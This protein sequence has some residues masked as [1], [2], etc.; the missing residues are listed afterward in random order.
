LPAA[1]R[2]MQAPVMRQVKAGQQTESMDAMVVFELERYVPPDSE[3]GFFRLRMIPRQHESIGTLPKQVVFVIDSSSSILQRKLDL[4]RRG[5][6]DTVRRLRP[7]DRFNIVLF[8]DNPK[9]FRPEPVSPSPQTFEALET[10]LDDLESR[11]QTDVYNSI[12]PVLQSRSAVGG[13]GIVM[14]ITDGR[15]TTGIQDGRAIINALTQENTRG[16]TV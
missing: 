7:Q 16:N 5:L 2:I 12:R 1:E 6:L 8:R 13:P 3:R 14:V 10:F 11:G 4:T 15:P 9:S